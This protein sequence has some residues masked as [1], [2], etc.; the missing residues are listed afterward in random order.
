[1]GDK[2]FSDR[3]SAQYQLNNHSITS[4]PSQSTLDNEPI[5]YIAP[6]T[7]SLDKL[8]EQRKHLKEKDERLMLIKA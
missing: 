7:T 4:P 1:M 5:T 6:S 3:K 8:K 2:I